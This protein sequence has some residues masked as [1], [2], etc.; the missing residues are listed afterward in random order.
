[1]K[2][3]KLKAKIPT[4]ITIKFDNK[5]AAMHFASWLCES[6]EQSYWDWQ[7]IRES[8]E[9]GDITAIEFDYHGDKEEKKIGSKKYGYGT[10]MGDNII[11]TTCGRLNR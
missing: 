10:F 8:E 2:K 6:G 11:R 4:D 1:M 3:S 9:D 7:E 5:E